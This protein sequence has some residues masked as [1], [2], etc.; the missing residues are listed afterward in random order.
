[1]GLV[2]YRNESNRFQTQLRSAVKEWYE[3]LGRW[4]RRISS[5]ETRLG[6]GDGVDLSGVAW[7]AA[8][9]LFVDRIGPIVTTGIRG[10]QWTD[11]DLDAYSAREGVL[12]GEICLDEDNMVQAIDTLNDEIYDATHWGWFPL[13]WKTNDEVVTQLRYHRDKI[14]ESLNHLRSFA[15]AVDGLFNDEIALAKAIATA[16]SSIRGGTITADGYSPAAGDGEKWLEDMQHY[17]NTH[18]PPRNRRMVF[19]SPRYGGNQG[20]LTARWETMSDAEKKAI[21]DIIRARFPGLTDDELGLVVAEMNSHGCGYVAGANAILEQYA[22][23]PGEF[24]R[25]FNF[26]LYLPDGSVNFNALFADYWCWMQQERHA[27]PTGPTI[28]TLPD[29]VKGYLE[30]HDIPVT[31]KDVTS[32]TLEVY[33]AMAKEGPVFVTVRPGP[34][35]NMDGTLA[36]EPGGHAMMVTGQGCDSAG[37]PY[38]VVSS[39]GKQ[40]YIYLD[41][42]HTGKPQNLLLTGVEFE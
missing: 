35:F 42:T 37:R 3:G 2:W 34:M 32:P 41:A 31:T 13:P 6:Q 16:V 27:D 36:Q 40:Y 20:D 15:R 4:Q 1:M 30:D 29:G 14:Q 19:D 9:S 17:A 10:C 24:E 12:A 11:I 33:A 22:D 28:G 39:W 23:R 8:K 26:P 7:S 5:L 25:I 38:L 18:P 21:A